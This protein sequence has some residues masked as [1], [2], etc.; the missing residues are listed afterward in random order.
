MRLALTLAPASTRILAMDGSPC[1]ELFKHV[2]RVVD[3]VHGTLDLNTYAAR[4]GDPPS[5]SR[6]FTSAPCSRSDLTI[7]SCPA[8][9]AASKALFDASQYT[10][11]A[12]HDYD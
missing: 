2:S 1:S 10:T 8:Y 4:R 9:A 6:I 12:K 11:L 5:L 7:S 3:F